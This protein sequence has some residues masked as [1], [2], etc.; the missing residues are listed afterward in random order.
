M[1][2]VCRLSLCGECYRGPYL[3]GLGRST[4]ARGARTAPTHYSCTAKHGFAHGG[5]GTAHTPPRPTTDRSDDS[6]EHVV[7]VVEQLVDPLLDA[8]L[9]CGGKQRL[10]PGHGRRV[11]LGAELEI[12]ELVHLG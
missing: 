10:Q 2:G 9:G 5:G 8:T 7:L 1:D 11:G 4:H 12:V 3:G 6:D